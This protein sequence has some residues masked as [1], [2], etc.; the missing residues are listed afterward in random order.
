MNI[1]RSL[2]NWHSYSGIY[3]NSAEGALLLSKM[4]LS[5]GKE[6]A[7]ISP[8]KEQKIKYCN[9]YMGIYH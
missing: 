7:F 4:H 2:G 9:A 6:K 3:P 5:S 8:V 1:N